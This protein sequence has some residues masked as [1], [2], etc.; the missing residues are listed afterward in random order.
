MTQPYIVK[1]A[2]PAP[3]WWPPKQV[4]ATLDY[5]LNISSVLAQGVDFISTVSVACAP[6]GSGELAIS[7][8]LVTNAV[9]TLTTSGGV[10]SRVYT[11][12]WVVTCSDGRIF[13]FIVYQSVPPIPGYI[14]P[15]APDPD[16][17]TP[18]V[19]NL[20]A[21]INNG[22]VV[23]TTYIGFAASTFGLP[24]GTFWSN[25][26]EIDA[27]PGAVPVLVPVPIYFSQLTPV[28]LLSLNASLFPVTSPTAG[29][30]QCWLNGEVLC[31]A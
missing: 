30:G 10:P 9:L 2:P 29:S 15:V 8:A 27:V 23:N 14:V 20:G 16:F 26:G 21:L 4:S 31:V 13:A 11:I 22:G 24:P 12:Q 25:G 7:N 3:N 1:A 19:P 5:S 28:G 6:S 17:G 18:V